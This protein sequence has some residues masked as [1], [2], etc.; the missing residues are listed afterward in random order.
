MIILCYKFFFINLNEKILLSFFVTFPVT[1]NQNITH[2]NEDSRNRM[3]R[4]DIY[5]EIDKP[6][7]VALFAGTTQFHKKNDF[8]SLILTPFP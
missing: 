6:F 2:I 7:G 8:E 1:V 3:S 5:Q 4:I